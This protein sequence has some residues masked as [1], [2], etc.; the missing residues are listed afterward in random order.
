M[1]DLFAGP[2][3]LGEGFSAF[4]RSGK[5]PFQCALSIEREWSAHQTLR[6]RAFFRAFKNGNVPQDYF[7]FIRGEIGI[8]ELFSSYPLEAQIAE[9]EAWCVELAP[10]TVNQ[11]RER[12]RIALGKSKSWI[13]LGGPPCQPFS[14][15]GRAR[16][17]KGT[18]YS[19]GKETRH[20]L[21]VEYLQIIADSWPTV[22]VMENVRGLLSAKYDGE[23]MFDR[24]VEDLKDPAGAVTRIPGRGRSR[25][26]RRHTYRL[27]PVTD[28][29]YVTSADDA[30][31][32]DYIVRSER[33]GIPQARHRLIVLGVRD[34]VRAMPGVIKLAQEVSAAD[35]IRGLPR[36]RGGLSRGDSPDAWF[37]CLKASVGKDWFKQLAKSDEATWLVANRKLEGL[38]KPIGNRGGQFVPGSPGVGINPGW[39]LD[40]R[41]GGISNHFSKGHMESDLHRYFFSASFADAHNRSPK[42]ADFP[43]SLLP[44]HESAQRALAGNNFA[45]RFRVQ[46]ADRPSNTVV[47]HIAKDGHYYIHYDATQCRSL[48]VREAARLQT[49]PDN[50]FF[51]GNGTQQYTQ[52]GNAVPPLLAK[53]IAKVVYDLLL[54][55]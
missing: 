49:F 20:Q 2:G 16:N 52:V 5:H 21:Y 19:D 1:I 29:G 36:I 28:Y 9:D 22:F 50:Y 3:G 23:R 31:S 25:S 18:R 6:L 40:S 54:K 53:Q 26:G 48:T 34:D 17:S 7:R 55:A 11:V 4:R 41:L 39:Y 47:S 38:K 33:H 51:M 10:S 12:I 45:D 35:A 13:L 15:A 27:F 14:I 46:V 24:I 30:A 8:S 37:A 42:L 44:R 32:N 43:S